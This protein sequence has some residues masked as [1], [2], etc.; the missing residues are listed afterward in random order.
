M[1]TLQQII[2]R[3]F[4]TRK[5]T[6]RE[7]SR[8]VLKAQ[9]VYLSLLAKANGIKIPFNAWKLKTKELSGAYSHLKSL[10]LETLKA[11]A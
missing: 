8:Y 5:L 10:K 11:T 3:I 7:Q 9:V 1:P 2:G 4:P 6:K